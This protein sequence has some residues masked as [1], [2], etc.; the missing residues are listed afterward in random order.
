[1]LVHC[2]ELEAALALLREYE[3]ERGA[4]EVETQSTSSAED[5]AVEELI[6]LLPAAAAAQRG[7]AHNLDAVD[8]PAGE[9]PK[10]GRRQIPW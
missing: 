6:A 8:V 2:G 7:A 4:V 5:A 9:A 3:Q 10:A 1:M